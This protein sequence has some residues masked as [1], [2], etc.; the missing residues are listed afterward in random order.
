MLS[1]L[2][3]ADTD[4]SLI[5]EG[6][7]IAVGLSGGK[8]SL[9]LLYAL[10]YYGYF[11]RKNFKVFPVYIDLGFGNSDLQGLK[12]FAGKLGY[13][14]QIDDSRFVYDVL[15]SHQKEGKHLPCSICSR[16][17]KAAIN[18]AA[19]RLKC[20]KVAFAHHLDDC[21]E[22]LFMNMVH[23]GKVA[24]FSPKMYLSGNDITFI[25]P[26]FYAREKQLI[27]LANELHFPILKSPC[28]A[29]GKTEREKSKL[30]L[31]RLYDEFP[32]AKNNFAGLLNNYKG[33]DMP[34]LS[35]EKEKE[36]YDGYTL[37]P[38]LTPEQMR[39]SGFAH[40]KAKKNEE[41]FLVNHIHKKEA[42]FAISRP[43]PHRVY[44]YGLNGDE[45]ALLSGIDNLMKR[46]AKETNPIFFILER[47]HKGLAK[48][49]GFDYANEPGTGKKAW[50]KRIAF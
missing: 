33:V 10:S 32:D 42:E 5:D 18:S 40:T 34:F 13:Q 44:I 3:R 16:M 46:L 19:H 48:A 50:V 6:D 8:D 20:N 28:P 22:T 11:A 31:F 47:G 4:Y 14:L 17:K 49:L 29:N 23:G 38:L 12:E 21:V 26:L 30:F 15:K 1:A 43:N 45:L 2:R 37:S 27:D 24:T 35:L 39:H 7:R 41:I 9:S 25:R 36:T